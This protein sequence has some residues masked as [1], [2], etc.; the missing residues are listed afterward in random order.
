MSDKAIVAGL[1]RFAVSGYDEDYHGYP[2]VRL[3]GTYLYN[4]VDF[5]NDYYEV[6]V[7]GPVRSIDDEDSP[8][9]SV[10]GPAIP[11]IRGYICG[12]I[13][14]HSDTEDGPVY[15]P[16][17]IMAVPLPMILGD[18]YA[19]IVPAE[20][21]E[22]IRNLRSRMTLFGRTTLMCF[23]DPKCVIDHIAEQCRSTSQ[24]GNQGEAP[25]TFD[26]PEDDID[27]AYRMLMNHER[28][29]APE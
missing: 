3:L 17:L 22:S 5:D 19:C 12:I 4:Y 14:E 10:E 18:Y 1:K 25:V 9:E 2:I 23:N 24:G 21:L 20:S 29:D 27:R 13:M 16:S 15:R 7:N 26:K 28:G 6:A 8:V 11:K